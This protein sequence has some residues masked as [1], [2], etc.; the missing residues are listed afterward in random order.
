MKR[1]KLSIAVGCLLTAVIVGSGIVV[2]AHENG[3]MIFYGEDGKTINLEMSEEMQKDIEKNGCDTEAVDEYQV[4]EI[5][6]ENGKKQKV[7]GISE[8]GCILLENLEEIND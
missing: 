1:K 7:I 2:S 8:E 5:I 3:I 4:G 6:Y